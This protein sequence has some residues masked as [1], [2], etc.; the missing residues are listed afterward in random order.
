MSGILKRLT[1]GAGI[2]C[3]TRQVSTNRS[4]LQEALRVDV[5][6]HPHRAALFWPFGQH[7]ADEA[8]DVGPPLALDKQ[9][10]AVAAAEQGQ[11]RFG[12][13]EHEQIT[14]LRRRAAQA[15]RMALGL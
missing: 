7:G 3:K 14:G 12:G 1:F 10:E 13:A 6:L 8:L 11:R 4:H 5:D 15:A 9:A 2:Y